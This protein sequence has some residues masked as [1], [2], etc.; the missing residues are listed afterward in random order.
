MSDVELRL[1]ADVD[2]AT[3]NVGSFRKEY[4]ELVKAVEKPLRQVNAFR[5]LESSLE[6]A[7][8]STQSARARLR[9]LGN[10]LARTASPSKALTESYRAATSELRRLERAESS[11]QT[12][13]SRRR[14]ELQAAGVDTRNL[15]AEQRRLGQELS[16]ALTAGRADASITSAKDA[17]GVGA[18]E[19]AQRALVE[20]R[21][22]YR[23]VAADGN[24]S[25]KQR[26][27]AEAT[28]RRSVDATLAKLRDLRTATA[29]PISQA[30]AAAALR[31]EAQAAA[32]AARENEKLTAQRALGVGAIEQTQRKLIALRQQ[33]RLVTEDGALSG[34]QRAEAESAYH[35]NVDQTLAKLR[36]LR[37]AT[38]QQASQAQQAAA[39]EQARHAQ[40]RMGIRQVAAEQAK[41]A[42]ASRQA[43][44]EAARNDLGVTRAR[45]AE[46]VLAQLNRQY[47]LIRTSG[48]LT[49]REL[50][51]AQ[52]TYT[53]K[54]RETRRELQ[55]MAGEQKKLGSISVGGVVGG[56]AGAAGGAYAA[57]SAMRAYVGLTDTSK[58]LDAQLRIATNSQDEFNR[59]QA[60]TF[61][62]AQENQAPMEAVV[63]TYARLVPAL[64]QI[65]RRHDAG[66]VVEALTKALRI[67][68]SSAAE[69]ASA[70]LQ[71]SQAMGS[72]VLRGEE[73]NAVA[74]SAPP[75]MRALAAGLGVPAG[76]LRG[77][78]A[79]GLL[80]ADVITDLTVNALPGLTAAAEKLPDTVDGAL[81]RLRNDM[82]K[83][84]GKGDTSGLIESITK[85]RALLTD[86]AV[87]QGLTD[88]AAG[89]AT[90]AGWAIQL[91][92]GFANFAK[93]LAYTAALAS[94]EVDELTKL[95]ETLKRVKMAQADKIGFTDWMNMPVGVL[96]KS[97]EELDAWAKEL[98]GKI[99]ASN[100][101]IAGMTLEAY[102]AAQ[103]GAK[104]NVQAQKEA[105][106]EKEKIDEESANA[107]SRYVAANIAAQNEL[108]TNAEKALKARTAIEKRASKELD[109]ARKAQL[110]T[111]KRYSDALA[112]L[113]AGG[114]GQASYGGAQQLKSAAAQALESNDV[115]RAKSLA[116][117]ALKMLDE[118]ADA[119][120]N[121]Y[122]FEGF[123][124]ELAAIERQADQINIDR[125]EKGIAAAKAE[126]KELKDLLEGIKDVVISVKMDDAAMALAREQIRS[127]AKEAGSAVDLPSAM[128]NP[129]KTIPGSVDDEG[130]VLLKNLPPAPIDV[131]IKE[132]LPPDGP[133]P[134]VDATINPVAIIGDAQPVAV[135]IEVDQAAA[136]V[137]QGQIDALAQGFRR[138]LVIPVTPV[139]GATSGEPDGYATGGRV[140]GPGT[141]TSDSILARLSNGEFVIRADA[142]RHYGPELLDRLNRRQLPGFADG[143][144]V[145]SALMPHVPMP[146]QAL[147]DAGRAP[148]IPHLGRM[149]IS[150]GGSDPVTIQGTP[151]ALRELSNAA[152]KFGRT[153]R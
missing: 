35:R 28:Y 147:L 20:L 77:M 16:A 43:S 11:A 50:A 21:Q 124:Q 82:I 5:E 104:Q 19:R 101:R 36:A 8:R 143:G 29:A 117:A 90:L 26:A 45:Q 47:Q 93:E 110:D 88:L 56:V 107:Y 121:T 3:K 14:R 144:V 125:A 99:E 42:I 140:R 132:V 2:Q 139:V 74:E 137:A 10:E 136:A 130:Y 63:A 62:I 6:A 111:E 115:E 38:Q 152:R 69:S 53:R 145:S 100:A 51:I 123:I 12:Q 25:G 95:E 72:G 58:K 40:A 80:T 64:D 138:Q 120:E 94:G 114:G 59:A 33:Y 102:R 57:V 131:V 108:V 15:A 32:S 68:G 7:E 23:L 49:T 54:I 119:G 84:F 18:I 113:S 85:L 70:L 122:G 83:S 76:A 73:F 48:G 55:G 148:E 30:D 142:V 118:L 24:L 34:K 22:Q 128:S 13:L 4:A 46:A 37:Q 135:G 112:K 103:E 78:A 61:R 98:E 105:A 146:S 151:D 129:S 89:M 109:T 79:E 81:T 141:G 65:G 92:A 133:R 149:D 106:E 9:E 17:L 41:A 116:Q 66:K 126:T 97:R 71:F 96:D 52:E 86:P 67:N 87:V 60:D 31:Q 39:A 127:L 1:T 134:V 153:R 150:L 44:I 75:L 91:G 27:E